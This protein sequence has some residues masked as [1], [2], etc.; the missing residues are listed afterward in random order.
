MWYLE[1]VRSSWNSVKS[2]KSTIWKLDP[3]TTSSPSLFIKFSGAS[4][5]SELID[6]F[7]NNSKSA[8]QNYLNKTIIVSGIITEQSKATITLDDVIFCSFINEKSKTLNI[9][10][11][12]FIKGRCIGYDDLLEQVKIDQCTIIEWLWKN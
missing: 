10:N 5:S 11:K 12:V 2:R 1:I 8:E 6:S 3:I 9:K 7:K 4:L